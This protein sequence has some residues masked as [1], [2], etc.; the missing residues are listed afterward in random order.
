ML[1]LSLLCYSI[2]LGMADT[3]ILCEAEV[4]TSALNVIVN[5]VCAP[6]MVRL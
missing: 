5:L 6:D 1:T 2:L 3:D 4:Q